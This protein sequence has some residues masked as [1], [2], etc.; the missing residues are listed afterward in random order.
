MLG[1]DPFTTAYRAFLTTVRGKYTHAWIYCTI[2]PLL[3]GTGLTNATAYINAM[4]A[5]VN[6]DGDTKVKVVNFGQQNTM[7]GTGCDYHPNA[8]EHQRMAGLLTTE[9][10]TTLGW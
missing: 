2:G 4:V 5:A 9:L 8:T 1:S 7:L 10:R 6:A 3:Y